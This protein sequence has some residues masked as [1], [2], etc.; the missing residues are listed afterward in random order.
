MADAGAQS[1]LDHLKR[2]DEVAV[3]AYAAAARLVDVFRA[4]APARS[5]PLLGQSG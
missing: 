2:E 3:M 1:A 4:N 5:A